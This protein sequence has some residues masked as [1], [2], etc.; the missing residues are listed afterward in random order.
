MVIG[1]KIA[2]MKKIIEGIGYRAKVFKGL[3]GNLVSP[4]VKI[5][6]LEETLIR[7]EKKQKSVA[8][9]GDGEF[10]IIMGKSI[11]FQ[12]SEIRLS[13]A[14]KKVLQSDAERID[15]GL[16]DIFGYLKGMDSKAARFWYVY[17]TDNRKELLSMV[18]LNMTYSNSFI[19]R[20]WTGYG[21]ADL[22]KRIFLLYKKIWDNRSVVFVEGALTRMGVGN[23]LFSNAQ[24]IRRVLCPAQNAWEKY[25]DILEAINM[26]D[27]PKDTLFILA[28]G[29]TATVLAYDLSK[30]GYQAL[31]LGH[32]DIQ[33]EYYLRKATVKQAIVGK[34][35]NENIKGRNVSDEIIDEEYI[36]SIL[37]KIE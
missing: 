37:V 35:V 34:Y 23:D 15:I 5:R 3:C 32:L 4:K 22:S 30:E 11:G 9:F 10:K 7:I 2:D 29:P 31:D 16:P 12:S 26:L 8:R 33:Y 21:D 6:S 1:G 27:L 28:L 14:L 17:M 19:T 36:D 20:I 13:Q 24:S 25:D 18:D